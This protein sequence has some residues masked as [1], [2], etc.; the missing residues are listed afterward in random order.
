MLGVVDIR[1]W[2]GHDVVD[3]EGRGI[4]GLEAVYVDTSTD[5]PSLSAV[6]AGLPTR[7]QLALVPLGQAMVR[8]GYL[9]VGYSRKS[10]SRM[11]RRSAPTVNSRQATKSDLPDTTA[12]SIRR[13]P[14]AGGGWAA[15][16]HATGAAVSSCQSR[17]HANLAGHH[18][19]AC[20]GPPAV[21]DAGQRGSLSPAGAL[22]RRS[23]PRWPQQAPLQNSCLAMRRAGARRR[24]GIGAGR[25]LAPRW[26]R[27]YRWPT[28]TRADRVRWRTS[29]PGAA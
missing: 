22:P 10:G 12:C 25:A 9:K 14:T 4:G 2:R 19:A 18:T 13:V 21:T 29:G 6:T 8:P 3:A 26:T 1:E 23:C 7:H 15:T 27:H 16:E 20:S 17:R 5:L 28:L 24:S 11:P